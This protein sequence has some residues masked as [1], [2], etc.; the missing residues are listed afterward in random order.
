MM[1][2]AVYPVEFVQTAK[3]INVISVSLS[4]RCDGSTSGKPQLTADEVPQGYYG[5]LGGPVGRGYARCRIPFGIREK[6]A[7]P[8]SASQRSV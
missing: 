6:C 8:G 1:S 3:Q 2:V 7:V 4:A 5:T